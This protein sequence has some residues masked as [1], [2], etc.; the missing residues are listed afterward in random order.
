MTIFFLYLLIL[1]LPKSNIFPPLPRLLQAVLYL[2]LFFSLP[3]LPILYSSRYLIQCYVD[4]VDA[5][6]IIL[7]LADLVAT[8]PTV[9]IPPPMGILKD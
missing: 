9:N 7:S 2:F 3:Y 8:D 6:L 4:S 5:L 1:A